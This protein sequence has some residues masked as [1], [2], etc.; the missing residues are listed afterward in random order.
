LDGP[1]VVKKFASGKGNA[2]K[3]RMYEA[4]VKETGAELMKE[5]S[6]DSKKVAS[7]VSDIVDSYFICKY[8]YSTLLQN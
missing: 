2:D 6:P 7:P 4:F 5:I 8:A 1:T 3:D